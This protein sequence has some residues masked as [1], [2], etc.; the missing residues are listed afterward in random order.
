MVG[1]RACCVAQPGLPVGDPGRLSMRMIGVVPIICLSLLCGG[2]IAAS[3]SAP[4]SVTSLDSLVVL[5]TAVVVDRALGGELHEIILR[6]RR[7]GWVL[8]L[9][10][11]EA[12]RDVPL[13]LGGKSGL[14][15]IRLRLPDSVVV[16]GR[17]PL[18]DVAMVGDSTLLLLVYKRL[19]AYTRVDGGWRLSA[20]AVFDESF[21]AMSL[22]GDRCLLYS[23][24]YRAGASNPPA[25]RVAF[26]RLQ[27]LQIERIAELETPHGMMFTMLQP[28]TILSGSSRWIAVADVDRYSIRVYDHALTE[29][30][31]LSRQPV[32]WVAVPQ[33][34]SVG[35]GLPAK[36]MIADL[37]SLADS[38][39][40]MQRIA[41]VDDTTM[42]VAYTVPGRVRGGI[43]NGKPDVRHDIWR[44]DRAAWRLLASDMP[45]INPDA[46]STIAQ[47]AAFPLSQRF[48]CHDNTMISFEPI[49]VP[50][51]GR[52]WGDVASAIEDYLT[53]H[54]LRI[55]VVEQHWRIP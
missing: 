20:H 15:E 30:C 54:E 33:A 9:P 53:E 13:I 29:R 34:E 19:L 4:H 31:R 28:R 46:A 47:G 50:M 10:G 16:D 36:Q 17:T 55:S 42:L 51:L 41:F 26:V 18:K 25:T 38:G 3:R 39:S 21:E 14:E 49:P 35:R 7:S 40:L 6:H 27:S 8:Y 43:R 5:D 11:E 45:G 48:V 12:G 2:C 24:M 37:K 52:T 32:G 23:G 22:H 44:Y 1:L